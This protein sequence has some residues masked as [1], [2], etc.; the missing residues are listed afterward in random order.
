M[1]LLYLSCV[2]GFRGSITEYSTASINLNRLKVE[3]TIS[4]IRKGGAYNRSTIL[5]LRHSVFFFVD[6]M[7]NNENDFIPTP[8]SGVLNARLQKEDET[9]STSLT[10]YI[11]MQWFLLHPFEH[12]STQLPS[13]DT[14]RRDFFSLTTLARRCAEVSKFLPAASGSLLND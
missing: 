4:L 7:M 1:L 11:S 6:K 14:V 8:Y 3:T 2:V 5:L 12:L 13:C 10:F 9:N